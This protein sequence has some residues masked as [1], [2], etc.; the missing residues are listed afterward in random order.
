MDSHDDPRPERIWHIEEEYAEF[1]LP[2]YA[3]AYVYTYID[4]R[5]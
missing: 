2:V 1:L 3:N 4:V 5:S